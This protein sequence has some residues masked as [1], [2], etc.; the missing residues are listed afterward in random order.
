MPYPLQPLRW[1]AFTL[2]LSAVVLQRDGSNSRNTNPQIS[3]PEAAAAYFPPDTL[4]DRGNFFREYLTRIGEPSLLAPARDKSAVMYRLEGWSAQHAR[5]ISVRLSIRPDGSGEIV[6]VVQAGS[7]SVTN[8]TNRASDR[9]SSQ[10]FLALIEKCGFWS[11]PTT[12][13]THK[14]YKFDATIWVFEGVSNGHYHVV[15][16]ETALSSAFADVV[17]FMGREL[18]NLDPLTLPRTDTESKMK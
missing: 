1:L 6:S 3:K 4:G 5:F 7:P 9:L 18:A 13:Q 10:K 11:M 15:L 8:K 2:A 16:R 17:R 12:A 14:S